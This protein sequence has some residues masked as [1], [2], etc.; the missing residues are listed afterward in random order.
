MLKHERNKVFLRK[1]IMR[2]HKSGLIPQMHFNACKRK[3]T[4]SVSPVWKPENLLVINTSCKE[5]R[6][7]CLFS[8]VLGLRPSS[9]LSDWFF[10]FLEGIRLIKYWLIFT[11]SSC[12]GSLGSGLWDNEQLHLQC[13]GAR[14][15]E[16]P[17]FSCWQ[18]EQRRHNSPGNCGKGNLRLTT[19]NTVSFRWLV[20]CS[21]CQGFVFFLE[22][23]NT[24]PDT[25]VGF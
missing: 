15:P 7:W 21:K 8:T 20:D 12:V 13:P 14:K 22:E 25:N 24:T 10:L 18:R 17:A 16:K 5:V 4:Y 1:E 11:C 23:V 19:S 9:Q 6:V 3:K 2:S